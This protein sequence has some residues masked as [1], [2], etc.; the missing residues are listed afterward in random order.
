M[1]CQY[2]RKYLRKYCRISDNCR[3]NARIQVKRVKLS[4]KVLYHFAIYAIIIEKLINKELR[5]RVHPRDSMTSVSVRQ[6]R[7][8]STYIGI[9]KHTRTRTHTRSMRVHTHTYTYTYMSLSFAC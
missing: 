1:E 4:G 6:E 3:D 9:K 8:N 2:L 5:M 7:N